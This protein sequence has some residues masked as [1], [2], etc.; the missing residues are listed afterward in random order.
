MLLQ[1]RGEKKVLQ[2]AFE[3]L[4]LS[5]HKLALLC[6][7][8]HQ[9]CVKGQ[10]GLG[11]H[12]N[13]KEA[14]LDPSPGSLCWQCRDLKPSGNAFHSPAL[15]NSEEKLSNSPRPTSA[16]T[17]F[18]LRHVSTSGERGEHSPVNKHLGDGVELGPRNIVLGSHKLPGYLFYKIK[19]PLHFLCS[20]KGKEK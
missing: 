3:L 4:W 5:C 15:L 20:Q 13:G 19:W 8:L 7:S 11:W 2:A 18:N 17:N 10:D 16:S 12:Q 6:F 14:P 1:N 9:G